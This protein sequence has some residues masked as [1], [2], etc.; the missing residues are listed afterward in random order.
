MIAI[1]SDGLDNLYSTLCRLIS[2]KS[3]RKLEDTTIY[4]GAINGED[5]LF[6]DVMLEGSH[7]AGVISEIAICYPIT[8]LIGATNRPSTTP[9]KA[10]INS[11]GI[12]ATPLQYDV[13]FTSFGYSVGYISELKTSILWCSKFLLKLA[14]KAAIA[15]NFSYVFE[16]SLSPCNFMELTSKSYY[17]EKIFHINFPHTGVSPISELAS[18]HKLPSIIIEGSSNYNNDPC[19]NYN[20]DSEEAS[21]KALVVAITM[22]KLI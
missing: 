19:C 15:N 13:N 20:F 14:K 2:I 21:T 1:L 3:I 12:Y 8:M 18:F 6:T 5:V 4:I 22:A 17:S 10:S 11:L 16:S 9:Y 7:I